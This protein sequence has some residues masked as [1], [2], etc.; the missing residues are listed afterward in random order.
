MYN[1]SC[2]FVGSGQKSLHHPF[3]V[4]PA[5]LFL[6]HKNPAKLYITLTPMPSLLPKDTSAFYRYSGSLTT[7]GCNEVIILSSPQLVIFDLCSWALCGTPVLERN[8]IL[9]E[10]E[11]LTFK[12]Q[13][14]TWTLLHHP[15]GVSESQLAG[16]RALLDG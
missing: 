10:L 12:I 2:L 3:P 15:V 5:G 11:I 4:Y 6:L 7:P 8:K 9:I 14:V 13:V 16:L 1:E